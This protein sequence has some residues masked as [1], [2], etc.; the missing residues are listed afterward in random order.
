MR[1]KSLGCV[2]L[3]LL[4]L[5]A[6]QDL[7]GA[8]E[9]C[10]QAVSVDPL[11]ETAHVHMAHLHLQNSDLSAAVASSEAAPPY[12]VRYAVA[13]PPVMSGAKHSSSRISVSSPL[14]S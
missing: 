1:T 12:R 4:K 9:R 2:A 14:A 7:N 13:T 5:H 11:C 8:I 3:L 10:K 6:E